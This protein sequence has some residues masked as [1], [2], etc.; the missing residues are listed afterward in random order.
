MLARQLGIGLLTISFLSSAAPPAFAQTDEERSAA[1]A[2]ATQGADAFDAGR[3]EEAVDLFTRAEAL[4]HSPAHLLFIARAQ[5][6]LGQWVKA[7][8]TLQKIKRAQLPP[9]AS[10]AVKRAVEEGNKE[11]AQLEPQLPYVAT[12]VK[13]PSG[14]VQVLIDG[15]VVPPLLV[16]LLRPIDPGSHQFQAK[17]GELASDVVTLE[18]TPGMK[19]TVEL[20]LKPQAGAPA[21][22]PPAAETEPSAQPLGTRAG[23]A[24]TGGSKA[25]GKKIAGYAAL[26]VGAVGLGLGTFFLVKASGTQ[27]DADDLCPMDPCSPDVADEVDAK[28]SDAASQRT[29]AAVGFA[30]GVVGVGAGITLLLLSRKTDKALNERGVTPYFGFQSAGVVGRF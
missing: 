2:A 19:Q 26:G 21:A 16:G 23:S 6:K 4:V 10:P 15:A 1:R 29:T 3:W 28:D 13:N 9:N 14:D 24:D 17:S 20:E 25:D 27:S 30:V 18:V 22:A 5:L 11:L 12:K 7:Y 8:E